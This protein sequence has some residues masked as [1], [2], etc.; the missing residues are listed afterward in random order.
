MNAREERVK[1]TGFTTLCVKYIY[2]LMVL[3]TEKRPSYILNML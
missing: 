3:Y 2:M 1:N